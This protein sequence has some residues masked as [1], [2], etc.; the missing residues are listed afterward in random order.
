MAVP[1]DRKY[2]QTHEWFQVN[3]DVVTVGITKFAAD[4]LTDITYVELPAVGKQLQAGGAFGEVESVKASSELYTA[5]SGQVTE[6]NPRLAGE[7]ELLNN[8]PFAAGWMVRLRCSDLAPLAK[9]MDAA[10]YEKM[11]AG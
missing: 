5:V 4:E 7:P 2:S 6:T 8:D 10:G 9:L 11:I 1:A 3:G